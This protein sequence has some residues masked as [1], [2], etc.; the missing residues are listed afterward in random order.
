MGLY[1]ATPGRAEFVLGSPVFSK[2]TVTRADG[3]V[4]IDAPAAGPGKP[5]V[6]G[7][8]LD[9]KAASRPWLPESF[10]LHGGTLR[11]DLGDKPQKKW[12]AGSADAPPSFDVH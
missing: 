10:A 3:N 6:Q 2:I 1:P 4:V 5:Y 11:F 12:G 9:G 8:K 7:L